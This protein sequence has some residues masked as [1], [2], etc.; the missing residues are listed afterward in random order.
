METYSH[1]KV[2]K[3]LLGV[4][5][6][7]ICGGRADAKGKP[8]NT[9]EV[10]REFWNT[11]LEARRGKGRLDT[12]DVAAMMVLLKIARVVTGYGGIDSW[13]DA[14]GYAIIGADEF[15]KISGKDLEEIIE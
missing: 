2:R 9:T 3:M 14:A 6:K 12:N 8:E 13:I 7:C 15:I 5:E 10:I 4:V 11:Y 1:V